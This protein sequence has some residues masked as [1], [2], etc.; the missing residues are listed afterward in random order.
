MAEIAKANANASR[1]FFVRML[2]RDISVEDCILDLLDNSVDSA[3]KAHGR[4][5]LTIKDGPDF[6]QVR[7]DLDFDPERFSIVDNGGGMSLKSAIDYAM[8]FG[9][10]EPDP[11]NTAEY[12]IGVYGIGLKRAIFKIGRTIQI[13]STHGS[14]KQKISFAVPIEVNDWVKDTST[15][16]DFPIMDA[17]PLPSNGLEIVIDNLTELASL[18]FED[19]EFAGTLMETIGRDYALHLHHGLQVYVNGD[20]VVGEVYRFYESDG[21]VPQFDSWSET[22]DGKN[23]DVQ[24]VAGLAFPPSDSN[25]P[26]DL[27]ERQRKSGWY[28]ACNGRIVLAADK[29]LLSVWGDDFPAWHPQY[30]GFLGLLAFTSDHTELLP[31]TTTKRSVD[32]SSIVYRRARPRMKE[33]TRAWVSY[34]NG[35]KSDQQAMEAA[36]KAATR[37]PIFDLKPQQQVSLPRTTVSRQ[38]E[39]SVQFSVPLVRIKNLAKAFGD[40]KMAYRVVGVKAFDYAYEE[41]V[42]EE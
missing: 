25:E 23:V 15:D 17:K 10:N 8:T 41:L 3:W 21:F 42:E 38:R 22:I 39:G 30:T 4:Q 32:L 13:R 40:G 14:G 12:S 35:R 34:T 5:P 18:T 11:D 36:E 28:V 26:T 1:A 7:I 29:T 27:G 16:W 31:L 6:S 9:R 24:I 33:T 37:T 2:T 20:L 19:I